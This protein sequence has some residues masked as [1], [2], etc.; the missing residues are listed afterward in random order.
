MILTV[1]RGID[2]YAAKNGSTLWPSTN[3]T[4]DGHPS[5]VTSWL[6]KFG[7]RIATVPKAERIIW[8]RL[9]VCWGCSDRER[10]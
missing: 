5:H 10:G 7:I 1:M 9:I 6:N 8:L 2:G 4:H 3:V